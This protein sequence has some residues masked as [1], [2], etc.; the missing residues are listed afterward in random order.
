GKTLEPLVTITAE[1]LA[2]FGVE[3]VP[4]QG[5]IPIK[6][7]KEKGIYHIPRAPGDNHRFVY[8]ED[9]RRDPHAHPLPSRSGKL[10]IHCQALADRVNRLGWSRIR[11][12]PT[13]S[14]PLEGYEATF[15]DWEKRIKGEYPLQLYNVH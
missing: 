3:G 12:I 8:L 9:F 14:P 6:E 10:E 7:F 5:R 1:D 4:Q 13:Y 15:S 2:E 11:P